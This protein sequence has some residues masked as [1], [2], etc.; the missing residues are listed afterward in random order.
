MDLIYLKSIN[1]DSFIESVV[2][3]DE[4]NTNMYIIRSLWA[5]KGSLWR[6]ISSLYN[7]WLIY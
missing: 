6:L 7:Q 3:D 5:G 2:N 4:N 1:L